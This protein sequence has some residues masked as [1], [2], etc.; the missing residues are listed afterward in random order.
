MAT[1]IIANVDVYGIRSMKNMVEQKLH[2][3]G[4]V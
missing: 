2:L 1:R 4:P 3:F